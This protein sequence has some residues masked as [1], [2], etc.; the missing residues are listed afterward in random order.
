MKLIIYATK[1]RRHLGEGW[2]I[3]EAT[4]ESEVAWMKDVAPHRGEREFHIINSFEISDEDAAYI[5]YNWQ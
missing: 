3:H 4:A 1:S 2:A 5:F